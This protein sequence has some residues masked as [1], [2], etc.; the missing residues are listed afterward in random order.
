MTGD[1]TPLF[2]GKEVRI[3]EQDGEVWLPLADLAAAWGIDRTTPGKIVTRNSEAFE[4]FT[5]E[6]PDDGD[7]TSPTET[8]INE[9]GLYLLMGRVSTDR[10]K[11]PEA[12]A[13]I[14]R[15]QRWVPELIQRYRKG[16]LIQHEALEDLIVKHLKIADGMAQFGHVDRG[17]AVT[18]ELTHVEAETGED[19]SRLKALVRRERMG[20]AAYLTP[21]RIGLEL[22]GLSARNVNLMLESL[23]FQYRVGDR[24]TPTHVGSA[25]AENMPYTV[26][27]RNG[28]QHSDYQLLWSPEIVRKLRDHLN[29]VQDARQ[30]LLASW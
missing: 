3:I 12:R 30:A 8:V 11:N 21:T 5:R 6:Y 29:G 20:P 23:G 15:F 1:L 14:L 24:W 27:L 26:T 7:V 17:I 9:R 4:G 2:E 10:L 22:G 19:L 25:Y 16:E 28:G 13:T 18:V